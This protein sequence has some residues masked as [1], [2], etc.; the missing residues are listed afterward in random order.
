MSDPIA[1]GFLMSDLG[2]FANLK[3]YYIVKSKK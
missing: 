3:R 1:V 2:E